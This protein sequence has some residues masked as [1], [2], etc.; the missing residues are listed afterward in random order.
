MKVR[1]WRYDVPPDVQEEFEREY[2]PNGSWAQLFAS[3]PGFVA[4]G[5]YVEV[6]S[7]TSYL[8]VDQFT[9]DD[10]WQD[11][12]T[13]HDTGYR[14]LGERLRHLTAVQEKLV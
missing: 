13:E 5:L 12:R 4:T 3:S 9:D 6:E 11:F 10:A 2:G 7:P 14:A 8:T 1:V